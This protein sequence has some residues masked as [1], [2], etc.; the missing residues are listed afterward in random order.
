LSEL[1]RPIPEQVL[2]AVEFWVQAL[3]REDYE[4]AAAVLAQPHWSA[5]KLRETVAN[6]QGETPPRHEVKLCEPGPERPE[7]LGQVTYEWNGHTAAF[8][9]CRREGFVTLELHDLR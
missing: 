5:E 9:L 4:L 1:P 7:L 8:E 6:S 3:S 2:K